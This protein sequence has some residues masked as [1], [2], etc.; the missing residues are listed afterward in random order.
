MAEIHTAVQ[1]AIV[2]WYLE[3]KEKAPAPGKKTGE[4]LRTKSQQ[5]HNINRLKLKPKTS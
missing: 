4:M 3:G 5:N 2:C 1:S